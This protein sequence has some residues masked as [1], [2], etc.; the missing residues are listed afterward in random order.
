MKANI[1]FSTHLVI[2]KEYY[3][4]PASKFLPEWYKNMESYMGGKKEPIGNGQT[5]G[6][7][8]RCLP[9][10]DAITAGYIITLPADVFI[11][12][13]GGEPYY[14]WTNFGLIEFHP[15]EQAPTYPN[16]NGFIYPKFM[17]PWSIQTPKGY[18]SLFVQPFHRD[19]VFTIM[20]GIVDTDIYY[21]PV[22]FPFILNDKNYE[23]LIPAGTPIAQ[24]IPIKRNKWQ[25]NHNKL[26]FDPIM[27][28]MKT[29]MFDK[30]KT[31]FWAKK[32]YK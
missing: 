2:E 4:Q 16:T 14:E 23:G 26:D 7:I 19:S 3:P 15:V 22:N 29:K 28:K 21:A 10:F 11:S 24:V 30:Y 20:P 25:M 27:R 6:T 13:K 5:S 31:M 17:N 18:S 9:V 8:K 1:T 32:D 12:Q